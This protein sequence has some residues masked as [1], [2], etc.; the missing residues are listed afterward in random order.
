MFDFR[1]DIW[2]G[3]YNSRDEARSHVSKVGHVDVQWLMK[4]IYR[5]E[6]AQGNEP[7]IQESELPEWSYPVDAVVALAAQGKD[8]NETV[9]IVDVGGNLGVLGHLCHGVIRGRKI[10]YSVL[11][12]PE[13][14]DTV[15][16]EV[17]SS[18]SHKFF[19]EMP[20]ME[21]DF[22]VMG[23]VIQYFEQPSVLLEELLSQCKSQFIGIFDA[24]IGKRIATFTS[25]QTYFGS[26]MVCTFYSLEDVNK[27]MTSLG[28][29]LL[30]ER[31]HISK[32]SKMYFP[33][34]GLPEEN[35]IP[36]PL[37]LIYQR[38]T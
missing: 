1:R 6:V 31:P 9:K 24:M 37:N 30:T 18:Q 26:S 28:Y 25:I 23:S 3:V 10:D 20:S 2:K 19:I 7:F 14:L 8:A 13:F 22:M 38:V 36:F 15:P 21:I 35:R 4:S 33:H 27:M 17:L 16:Q 11:E 29:E 32:K 12:L 34:L 5:L